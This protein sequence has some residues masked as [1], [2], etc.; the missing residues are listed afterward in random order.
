MQVNEIFKSIYNQIGDF[1]EE[2]YMELLPYI[3]DKNILS[4]QNSIDIKKLNYEKLTKWYLYRIL[5]FE[6]DKETFLNAKN[7][8]H[9]KISFRYQENF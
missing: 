7:Q 8:C 2:D 5:K 1:S 9:L 4:I 3:L 6:S